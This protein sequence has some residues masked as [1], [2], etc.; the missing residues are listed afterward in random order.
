MSE[1]DRRSPSPKR[2]KIK[3]PYIICTV[4][5]RK[6]NNKVDPYETRLYSYHI[7]PT[8]YSTAELALMRNWMKDGYPCKR[9]NRLYDATGGD[10]GWEA[11][12]KLL[13]Q[14]VEL[15]WRFRL[16]FALDGHPTEKKPRFTRVFPTE[17]R[18]VAKGRVVEHITFQWK[19]PMGGFWTWLEESSDD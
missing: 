5:V 3:K 2:K 1:T 19:V 15:A 4:A 13:S 16:D 8:E 14:C 11:V 9:I 6:R 18:I 7:P 10:P 17:E 12:D